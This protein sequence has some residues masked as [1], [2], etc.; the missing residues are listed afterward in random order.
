MFLVSR[1]EAEVAI[2]LAQPVGNVM[3]KKLGFKF[4]SVE[5]QSAV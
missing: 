2:D 4:V 1:Q 5:V 3:P